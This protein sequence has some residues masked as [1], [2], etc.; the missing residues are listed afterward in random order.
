[1]IWLPVLVAGGA[2][3]AGGKALRRFGKPQW[4]GR[5]PAGDSQPELQ[6]ADRELALSA[7]SLGVAAAGGL[8][9]LPLL[10]WVSFPVTVFLLV[11][12]I[13]EAGQVLGKQRRINDQVLTTTRL[14]VCSVMGYTFIAALDAGL[15]ALTHRMQVR[16][17]ADWRQSL[18][19]HLGADGQALTGWLEQASQSPTLI[20]QQGERLGR[21]AAPLM[22]ATCVLSTPVLGINHSAAFLT[23][24]FGAH[25]RKLGPYTAREFMRQALEEGIVLT[26]PQLL[27]QA[28]RVDT[29]AFDGRVLRDAQAGGL[30]QALR[31]RQ[32]AVYVFDTEDETASQPLDVDGWFNTDMEGRAEQIR[33]WRSAGK[34]VCYI[35]DGETDAAAMRAAN[36]PVIQRKG[37]LRVEGFPC[38]LLPGADLVP[39]FRVLALAES[40]TSRQRFNLVMPIGVDLVDISTTLLLDFGLVYSVM[41]TYTGLMLGMHNVRQPEPSTPTAMQWLPSTA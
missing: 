27:D 5:K 35:G 34:T 24:F 6:Q 8:L 31:Q 25:L 1:M 38:V 29:L 22:L 13:R 23:T 2:V 14:A 10:G 26:H 36:L 4:F 17:E 40:F 39:L 37:A 15:H 16:N 41:F 28:V 11:P 9:Q 19:R 20:Q 30:V 12:V 33:Q 7:A 3:Y 21:Q 18:Q 32:C